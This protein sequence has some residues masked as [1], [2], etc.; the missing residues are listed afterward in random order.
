MSAYSFLSVS[1]ALIG[2]GA[3][4]SIGSDAGA[5]DEGISTS[6]ADEK[7]TT[8]AGAGGDLM[9]SLHAA[10]V[11]S[12]TVRLLKTSP[13]NALLMAAYNFQRLSPARWGQ[14]ALR[15]VDVDRGDVVTGSE[16]A[17]VK[18]PDLTWAKDGNTVEWVFRGKVTELLGSGIPVAAV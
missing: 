7:G 11:G 1:A 15:V 17:F 3:N 4:F 14:N 6:M 2:P 12:V 5:A 18:A 9:Q 13:V 10:N 16:M 8:T